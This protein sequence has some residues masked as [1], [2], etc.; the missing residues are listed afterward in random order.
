MTQLQTSGRLRANLSFASFLGH[1]AMWIGLAIITL[2][3]ALMFFPYSFLKFA[4][5]RTTIEDYEG[6]PIAQLKV[7][8]DLMNQIGHIVIWFFIILFTLGFGY[9]FYL[10]SVYRLV[11]NKTTVVKA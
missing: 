9:F 7:D 4:I 5:N 11:L 6:N 8:L 1:A 3:I 10:Y 2:G